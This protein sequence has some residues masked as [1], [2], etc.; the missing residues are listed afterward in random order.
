MTAIELNE[1]ISNLR[2]QEDRLKQEGARYG[3][4][5]ARALAVEPGRYN[6]GDVRQARSFKAR[7]DQDLADL[8]ERIAALEAQLPSADAIERAKDEVEIL[9]GEARVANARASDAWCQFIASLDATLVSASGLATSRAT[10]TDLTARLNR[11]AR[12]FA[13]AVPRQEESR[14]SANDLRFAQLVCTFFQEL[15]VGQRNDGLMKALNAMRVER[16]V[17]SEG[18]A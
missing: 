7:V 13:V 1:A 4:A 18:A 15:S 12:E 8:A 2:V 6:E 10:V 14:P 17:Q 9:I 11:L 16:Q 3:D 5:L